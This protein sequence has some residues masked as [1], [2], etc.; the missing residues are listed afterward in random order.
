MKI[1]SAQSRGRE[2]A[3]AEKILSGVILSLLQKRKPIVLKIN[4]G[5]ASILCLFCILLT[6]TS[7]FSCDGRGL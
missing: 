2:L 5:S 4:Y 6:N 1:V 3:G 7:D